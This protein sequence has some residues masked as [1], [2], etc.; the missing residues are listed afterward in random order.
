MVRVAFL[1]R[2]PWITAREP[3]RERGRERNIGACQS[4]QAILW[5]MR[6]VSHV[7]SGAGAKRYADLDRPHSG[8]LEAV[9]IRFRHEH[10]VAGTDDWRLDT[11]YPAHARER[12]P[13][14]EQLVRVEGRR[15]TDARNRR[16][17]GDI[18]RKRLQSA[19]LESRVTRGRWR[20]ALVDPL[21]QHDGHRPRR[22]GDG[23]SGRGIRA[24]RIR[25]WRPEQQSTR[26]EAVR[27]ARIEVHAHVRWK[28]YGISASV[29]LPKR[30]LELPE[31]ACRV[32]LNDEGVGGGPF[33]DAVGDPRDRI[34]RD[35]PCERRVRDLHEIVMKV[36]LCIYV[37]VRE[38]DIQVIPD[39]PCDRRNDPVKYLPMRLVLVE[40]VINEVVQVCTRLR[41]SGRVGAHDTGA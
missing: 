11:T 3:L 41:C 8:D 1:E 35:R 29:Y 21:V 14:I 10:R 25:S 9:R 17:R 16:K 15:L 31:L 27:C 19:V 22:V 4:A 39:T 36:A 7:P 26:V 6:G 40:A 18:I 12:R 2:G 33:H 34:R 20:D 30:A 37:G 28:R 23:S 32:Y 24:Q 38:S 5:T 13:P